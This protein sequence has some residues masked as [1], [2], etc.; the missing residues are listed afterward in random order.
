[1]KKEKKLNNNIQNYQNVQIY[2][3]HNNN[4]SYQ[5]ICADNNQSSVKKK[6]SQLI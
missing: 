6:K 2:S 5:N 3:T 4:I 1:M